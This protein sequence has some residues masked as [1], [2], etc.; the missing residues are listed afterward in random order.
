MCQ[1][2]PCCNTC[3]SQMRCC[4]ASLS[5]FLQ[6]DEVPDQEWIESV[7]AS[8]QPACVQ[9]GLWIVPRWCTPPDPSSVNI[10]LEPGLAF[11][12]GEHP[13]TRLCLK[14]LAK[15]H[16]SSKRVIDYGTGW[17][18]PRRG[19]QALPCP[20]Q[21]HAGG[22]HAL[23]RIVQMQTISSQGSYKCKSIVLMF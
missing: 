6:V 13:T 23:H 21:S 1:F 8:Y 4:S 3:P 20:K 18:L 9:E 22:H 16:L 5:C 17:H 10:I 12:T 15:L 7:K 11:G 19:F 2:V 14:A